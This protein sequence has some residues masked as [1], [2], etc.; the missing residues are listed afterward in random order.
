MWR[1]RSVMGWGGEAT[2]TIGFQ[3]GFLPVH[4]QCSLYMGGECFG[5]VIP[6]FP[7]IA[8]I[9]IARHKYMVK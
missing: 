4:S 8:Y 9:E 6:F 7:S 5:S 2:K 3:D 1:S